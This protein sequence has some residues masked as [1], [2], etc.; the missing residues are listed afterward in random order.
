MIYTNNRTKKLKQA[1]VL[2]SVL[3]LFFFVSC[4]KGFLDAK[5]RQS[6]VLV[7]TIKN[8]QGVLDHDSRMNYQATISEDGTDEYYFSSQDFYNIP[9]QYYKNLYTWAAVQDFY[10]GSPVGSWNGNYTRLFYANTA[11][12][13]IEKIEPDQAN[14][15]DWAN[16]KGSALFFRACCFYDLAQIFCKPYTK[17]SANLH[18]GVILRTK[19]DINIPYGRSTVK[20]TYDQVIDDLLAARELLP[21]IPLHRSRPSKTATDAMLA[22]V[23]LSM[24]DY[25]NAYFYADNCL[26]SFNTLIDYNTL[27]TNAVNPLTPYPNNQEIIFYTNLQPNLAP[28]ALSTSSVDTNLYQMYENNDLR[29]KLF[30]R[31]NNGK[32]QF[33]GSYLGSPFDF[34]GGLATDEILLIRAECQARNNNVSSAMADLYSLLQNRYRSNT[35]TSPPV[36]NADSALVR[37]LTERRKELCFRGTRWTDLRR[38][39]QENRFQVTLKRIID[40]QTYTLPPNDNRYVYPI[41]NSEILFNNIPQNPR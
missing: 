5:P 17:D 10:S 35:Y 19:T 29:K 4:K 3:C 40:S 28:N 15:S 1:F 32:R 8:L 39:N 7:N 38:L 25:T 31:M 37:I 11:L 23:Y 14:Y 41:P 34:F 30:F 22:R 12:E 2:L 16:I 6:I 21:L 27:D 26:Q 33:A 13:E 24:Q 20:Q 18:L 9:Y 36:S